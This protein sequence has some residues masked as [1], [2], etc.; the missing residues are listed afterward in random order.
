MTSYV[1]IIQSNSDNVFFGEVPLTSE[2]G[3]ERIST[4]KVEV[5]TATRIDR[6]ISSES[7]DLFANLKNY[8]KTVHIQNLDDIR[9]ALVR[10]IPVSIEYWGK[11][12]VA[13]SYDLEEYGYGETEFA[14][15]KDL[16]ESIVSIFYFFRDEEA[17]LGTD[18]K[19]KWEYLK[20]IIRE[21]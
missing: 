10:E 17:R 8:S 16:R 11:S 12:V 1:K 3:N 14:A 6:K 21:K 15:L 2:L 18:L 20:N 5:I 19:S 7:K 9:L 4:N 13:V